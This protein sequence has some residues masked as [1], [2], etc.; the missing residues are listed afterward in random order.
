MAPS[1]YE[2][3]RTGR[4]LT[5]IIGA[6]DI[7]HLE[8]ADAI[9]D[10][11]AAMRNDGASL[12]IFDLSAVEHFASACIGV[13]VQFLQDIEAVRGRIILAGCQ[14]SVKFLF[15]VTRLDHVFDVVDDV[16][17]ARKM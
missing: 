1:S 17:E 4:T 8:L 7:S 15:R 9:E 16:D 10:C 5:C 11:M 3:E 6:K 13:L 14:D 12:F 2:L